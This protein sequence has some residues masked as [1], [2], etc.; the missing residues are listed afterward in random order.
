MVEVVVSVLKVA[1]AIGLVIAWASVLLPPVARLL[2]GVGRASDSVGSFRAKMSVLGSSPSGP[3][4]D[5]TTAAASSVGGQVSRGVPRA[6]QSAAKK[7]RRDIL[8]GLLLGTGIALLAALT[9]GG[10]A[11]LAFVGLGLMLGA[12]VA[13]LWQ[14]Q[15]ATLE[16]QRK[17]TYFP[18]TQE[19]VAEPTALRRVGVARG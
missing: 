14:V 5:L 10:I 1:L 19:Q 12:Y 9:V 16:R 17:V 11:W 15:Q 7:R 8:V 6:R 2:G 4:L 13:L 3:V 18:R